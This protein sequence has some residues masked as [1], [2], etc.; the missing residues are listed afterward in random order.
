MCLVHGPILAVPADMLTIVV[1]FDKDT[2]P[3]L[4][5]HGTKARGAW[6]LKR[7]KY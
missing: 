6:T 5:V 2:A 4:L 1:A 3:K 7:K